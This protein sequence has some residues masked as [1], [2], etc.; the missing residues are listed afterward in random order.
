MTE[1]CL[2]SWSDATIARVVVFDLDGTLMPRESSS[3]VL[4]D[5]I[6]RGEA[7]RA[8]ERRYHAR[9]VTNRE[10]TDRQAAWFEGVT[11]TDVDRALRPG[12]WIDGLG[13]TLATLARAGCRL[14]LA[15]LAW[16]FVADVLA[17]RYPFDAVCG[18]EMAIEDATLTGTVTRY[19]DEQDKLC[20]VARWCADNGYSPQDVVAIG[21]SR[22][23]LPLFA[24]AAVS[25][26]LNATAEARAAAHHV[27]DTDDLRDLLPML[28]MPAEIGVNGHAHR[29]GTARPGLGGGAL[30]GGWAVLP[31]HPRREVVEVLSQYTG[32]PDLPNG[33]PC[34]VWAYM[35]ANT[36][37]PT[38]FVQGRDG[39]VRRQLEP[40]ALSPGDLRYVIDVPSLQP[41]STEP[42]VLYYAAIETDPAGIM[43]ST[44]P[45]GTQDVVA[46]RDGE[47]RV[48]ELGQKRQLV[49]FLRELGVIDDPAQWAASAESPRHRKAQLQRLHVMVIE[50]L[51]EHGYDVH[52]ESTFDAAVRETKEEHG[53]DLERESAQVTR[54]DGFIERAFSK[55]EAA[56]PIE[57]YVYAARVRHF[58]ATLPRMSVVTEDK[59]PGRE[60]QTYTERGLFLTLAQMWQRVADARAS[61]PALAG[62]PAQDGIERELRATASRLQMLDRIERTL[63]TSLGRQGI[64]VHSTADRRGDVA[65]PYNTSRWTACAQRD[66]I[67]RTAAAREQA[68]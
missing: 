6:G 50:A 68:R 59:D 7:C 56:A 40:E 10:I 34:G 15:T 24:H 33:R 4:A 13:D 29:R 31:A 60:G 1:P 28:V 52:V 20:F 61:R 32:Y 51:L 2:P 65:T 55:R 17:R 39:R 48:I 30:H 18:A 14:L 45:K 44:L 35:V 16:R 12:P 43:V 47:R 42:P 21:D 23:D 8:L 58:D 27:V 26:A 64:A 49:A 63:V 62:Q 38:P 19:F 37:T 41:S 25:I 53:F 9:D 54:V 22:S 5:A 11:L 3:A 57:H 36:T 46:R 66:A 67:A